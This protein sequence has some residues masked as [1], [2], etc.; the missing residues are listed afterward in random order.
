V[1]IFVVCYSLDP[2]GY[3][4][5]KA[6]MILMTRFCFDLLEKVKMSKKT[7]DQPSKLLK[8]TYLEELTYLTKGSLGSTVLEVLFCFFPAVDEI[9]LFFIF[10]IDPQH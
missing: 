8:H 6:Q 2:K 4:I 5:D 10:L 9:D 7:I 1:L 3:I